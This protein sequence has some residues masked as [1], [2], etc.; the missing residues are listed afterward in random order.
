MAGQKEDALDQLDELIINVSS[1]HRSSPS[2]SN[3]VLLARCWH[4]LGQ[5]QSLRTDVGFEPSQLTGEVISSALESFQYATVFDRSWFKGW[6]A[7]V[8]EP[9]FP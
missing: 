2:E 9:Y 6:E 5:W 4:K 8:S 1:I 7:W 3:Q